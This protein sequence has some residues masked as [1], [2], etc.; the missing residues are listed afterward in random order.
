MRMVN[1]PVAVPMPANVIIDDNT[2]F[3]P[4]VKPLHID[5]PRQKV[6]MLQNVPNT[7]SL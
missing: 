5:D 4:I 1:V 7:M 2:I 3:F 6:T